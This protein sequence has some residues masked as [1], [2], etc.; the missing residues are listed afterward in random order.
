MLF[1]RNIPP[2]ISIP[3]LLLG[4]AALLGAGSLLRN[5]Y[6]SGSDQRNMPAT[7]PP[8]NT[9]ISASFSEVYSWTDAAKDRYVS[10]TGRLHVCDGTEQWLPKSY[11]DTTGRAFLYRYVNSCCPGHAVPAVLEL[12]PEQVSLFELP[13]QDSW[14]E[15][16][17]RVLLQGQPGSVPKLLIDEF[18]PLAEEPADPLEQLFPA[19][20]MGAPCQG[21]RPDVPYPPR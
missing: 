3:L 1:R 10:L 17:G 11:E 7:Y 4:F 5:N 21:S 8:P 16:R 13:G 9:Y 18:R 14:V 2:A 19:S 12:Q 15:L 6:V 20:K